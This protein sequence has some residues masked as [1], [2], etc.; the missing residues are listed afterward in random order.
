MLSD[1]RREPDAGHGGR[2]CRAPVVVIATA[3]RCR[4]Q[5]CHAASQC[6]TPHEAHRVC[7]LAQVAAR[8]MD[9]HGKQCAAT[10]RSFASLTTTTRE[11]A[12]R[13]SS[14]LRAHPSP[15]TRPAAARPHTARGPDTSSQRERFRRLTR[16]RYISRVLSAARGVLLPR[17]QV[18][19]CPVR[20]VIAGEHV[21]AF[22]L[23]SMRLSSVP[24]RWIAKDRVDRVG[25][26]PAAFH[27]PCQCPQR[28]TGHCSVALALPVPL[29]ASQV[30]T[31]REDIV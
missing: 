12:L 19:T 24:H 31:L 8:A 7:T 3:G 21:V 10:R 22:A 11:S 6:R 16:F 13:S 4:Q 27:C 14:C 23:V 29:A 28:V 5:E 18:V 25:C 1:D 26:L 9:V 15:R 2:S 30:P 17:V 20:K